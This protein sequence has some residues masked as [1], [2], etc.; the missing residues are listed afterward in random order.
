MRNK[1]ATKRAFTVGEE[2]RAAAEAA[3]WFSSTPVCYNLHQGDLYVLL[4]RAHSFLHCVADPD[5]VQRN[6]IYLIMKH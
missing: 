2:I 6:P 3:Q 1:K 4:V 5:S